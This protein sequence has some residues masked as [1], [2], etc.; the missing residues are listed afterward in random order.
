MKKTAPETPPADKPD[1][2]RSSV[3]FRFHQKH[4]DKMPTGVKIGKRHRVK[5]SGKITGIRSDEYGHS[6]D[7]DLEDLQHEM[8]EEK[9]PRSL[10]QA[11]KRR[12]MK[13]GRFA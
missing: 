9:P 2:P 6:L 4:G 13:S 3:A 5:L 8:D 10:T 1:M 7:L 11:M 12:H